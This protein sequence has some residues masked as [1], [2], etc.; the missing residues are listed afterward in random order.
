[1]QTINKILSV[2]VAWLFTFMLNLAN[3]KEVIVIISALVATG[4]TI[5]R[6]VKDVGNRSANKNAETVL[7]N[8]RK[9]KVKDR[10]DVNS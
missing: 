10:K 5:Y 4:Y 8:N 7:R 2:W 3:I 9:L 1:M 6:W